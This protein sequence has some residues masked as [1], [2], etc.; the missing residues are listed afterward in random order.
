[1][2]SAL[3]GMMI[4]Q[5]RVG[6]SRESTASDDSCESDPSSRMPLDSSLSSPKSRKA[7]HNALTISRD[8]TSE[9]DFQAQQL[10][11]ATEEHTDSEETE[12]SEE[13]EADDESEGSSTSI[14]VRAYDENHSQRP[15]DGDPTFPS[16][17]K[18][19]ASHSLW[20]EATSTPNLQLDG[21]P[22][23]LVMPNDQQSE[24]RVTATN[25][26][27][28][29]AGSRRRPIRSLR[30]EVIHR[31]DNRNHYL[32]QP[33]ATVE[34]D[35]VR[36]LHGDLGLSNLARHFKQNPD[37]AFVVFR[38]YYSDEVMTAARD[39]KPLLLM[40]HGP[41]FLQSLPRPN[42]PLSMHPSPWKNETT[43]NKTHHDDSAPPLYS[44]SIKLIKSDMQEAVKELA[45]LENLGFILRSPTSSGEELLA[46]YFF[47]Y[48]VRGQR[49]LVRTLPKKHW[50]FLRLLEKYIETAFSTT[51]RHVDALLEHGKIQFKYLPFLIRPGEPLV[52]Q[53]AGL[54]GGCI[55]G[56]MVLRDTEDAPSSQE[57]WANKG[58]RYIY[59]VYC[60]AW[61]YRNASYV[62]ESW[63]AI[64]S[65]H[66][67][68][69]AR[70]ERDA[71][72]RSLQTYPLRFAKEEVRERLEKIG[73]LCWSSRVRKFVAYQEGNGLEAERFMIDCATYDKIH[74]NRKGESSR[75][76]AI[77]GLSRISETT[78]PVG[79][80][81]YAFPVI[82]KGFNI[83]RKTWVDLDVD[84]I[85]EVEW[86]K[87]AFENLA[88]S[89]TKTKD[90]IRALVT[91]QVAAEKGTDIIKG[92]G[93]GLILLMHGAPGTGKTFT[94]E[95]VAE[96][97]EKPLY[98]VTCGDVGTKPEDVEKYLE[99][100]LYL[101]KIWGCIVLL[102]EAEVFL[103][104][105][106]LADLN[107]NALVSVF[108]RVLEY[109]DGILILTSNRVGTFDEAFK[110]RI[111][112]AIHYDNLNVPQ[113]RRIWRNFL[114]RL[115]DIDG[116][117]IDF[118][119]I[120]DNLGEFARMEMNGRSIRNAIT[121]ARQLAKHKKEVVNSSH[122][123]H[124]IEVASRFDDYI[125]KVREGL[126]DDELARDGGYR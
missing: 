15:A 107:R 87:K 66:A 16:P 68:A 84:K 63:H 8:K 2:S 43:V 45:S 123:Q 80:E 97:T 81:I 28:H 55:A 51:Y 72:I 89:D 73:K 18:F 34:P 98:R 52:T 46:P 61:S 10:L 100:V 59:R 38:D 39:K 4:P 74:G 9:S 21:T 109:Y 115:K 77:P 53:F 121:T 119:D 30:W 40:P 29:H 79:D 110:S 118:E 126:T 122:L 94:A 78:G 76:S 44:E 60:H 103:E 114:A 83:Q 27:G 99:S 14:R 108:L 37:I 32:G 41:P 88:L 36:K 82:I 47:W 1:M 31:I 75:L 101:G 26:S 11:A 104:Q 58:P 113:R 70:T 33:Y 62:R 54:V 5:L 13:S 48:F 95:A 49:D 42:I 20:H 24:T 67:A 69:T 35:G 93:K 19:R 112:L 17:I 111:H 124:V 120:N 6:W 96:I 125:K 56:A 91:T 71:E 105:R 3:G 92:K 12:T 117:S 90:L 85:T 102:D 23:S 50:Q 106:G 64:V 25:E 116:E 86:D 22:G 65:E 7:L 57:Q